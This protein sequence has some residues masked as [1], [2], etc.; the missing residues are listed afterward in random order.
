MTLAG[1][2]G[3]TGLASDQ[4]AAPR[5]DSPAE[6]SRLSPAVFRAGLKKRGL[7]ELLELHVRDFPP[8]DETEAA[9]MLRE[10]KLA[11]SADPTL[12]EAE[13]HAALA[14]ANRILERL[15]QQKDDEPRRFLWMF[16][17]AHSLLYQEAEP[18]LTNILY[19]G[20]SA[21][22]R[23]RLLA[24]ST[25]AVAALTTLVGGLTAEYERLDQMGIRQF[26][27]LEAEGYLQQL[28][29]LAPRAEYLLLWALFYDSL[30]RDDSDPL[31]A[32]QLNKILERIAENPT[33]LNAP[34]E[35]S[36]VQVQALL[37][38][39]MSYRLLNDHQ[40][41]REH[42]DRALS[43]AEGTDE[44]AEGER[45]EW[46]VTLAW[47]ER[48]RNEADDGRFDDALE[49][50][51]Q[52]RGTISPKRGPDGFGLRIVA[53]LLERSV[54]RLRANLAEQS[55]KTS[56]AKQY[57]QRAWQAVAR[58]ARVEPDRRDEIYAGLYDVIGPGADPA[59][60]DP[61]ERCAVIAGLLS[62]AIREGNTS[63]SLDRAI[64]V[65][66]RFLAER[67]TGAESLVPEVLY[68]MAVAEY[69]RN[70]PAAAARR[71]LEVARDHASFNTAQQ[72]AA[73]AVQLAAE[74][75]SDPTL[76][77]HPGVRD[78]YGD[79]LALLIDRYPQTD[80]GRYWRFYY[81]QLLEES[82]DFDRASAQYALIDG[83]H[84]H[85]VEALFYRTRCVAATLKRESPDGTQDM[86]AH[87]Q[88]TNDFFNIQREFAARATSELNADPETDRAASLRSL[89]ARARLLAAEVQVMPRTDRPAQALETLRGFEEQYPDEKALAGRVWRGRLLAYE[90]LGRLDEATEAIPAYIAADPENAGPTLQSLYIALTE[91]IDKLEGSGATS[92]AQRKAG[93][94]LVLAQQIHE[95]A[96]RAGR[97]S[98]NSEPHV[99]TVQLAE[100]NLR[101]SRYARARELFESLL[102]TAR[103]PDPGQPE[104]DVRLILG[105]AESLYHLGDF[106]EALPKFNRL[107][108][109]L[110]AADPIRWKALLRDLQC[111][112]A[113]DHPARGVVKVIR[114]QEQ[115]YPDLGGPSVK[116]QLERLLRENER[117]IDEGP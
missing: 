16:D 102:P 53:A 22:D 1:G 64:E 68:N 18:Y 65:G 50:L 25:R 3:I 29:G 105:Y 23:Q 99:W 21:G 5:L 107:A 60:L 95:W 83:T 45:I 48:V 66:E 39:G 96:M 6:E 13:R 49:S 101:A 57:R 75:Y 73:F 14:E 52:F 31:R 12:P 15:I 56:H 27:A 46:A 114:Q 8:A 42:L 54:Y 109:R 58:L 110:P 71:F 84:E 4:R 104:N 28:D 38:T 79:G 10:V 88:R 34:H 35:T 20:G 51:A 40:R 67:P 98:T 97:S 37:L 63:P 36:H 33:I 112:T 87:Q 80:A 100:A 117:R 32:T 76:R 69:R 62:D 41:A 86:R 85:H 81:A 77:E 94:A 30:P 106:G 115:L 92:S 89:L 111:R 70:R 78:L 72:A 19:R 9:I 2:T 93:M 55:G 24:L 116:P 44:P 103:K 43:V 17:L 113:L 108:T 11:E 74:L 90:E 59:Q 61:L 82:G 47:L 26:E 7:T 91:D